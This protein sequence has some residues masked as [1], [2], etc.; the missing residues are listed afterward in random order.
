[1]IKR[2]DVKRVI[3][4]ATIRFE[5][6]WECLASLKNGSLLEHTDLSILQFQPTLAAA[7]SDLSSIYR[8]LSEEKERTIKKKS[9]L[10]YIWFA[11]RMR[12]LSSQQDVVRRVLAVGKSI[13]DGFAWFFYQN[14]T[15][16]LNEHLKE[17]PQL[18][19][20]SGVGGY[21]ELEVVKQIPVASGHFL[22]YHG[23]T[24][25]LRLGDF[26]L[27]N[28]KEF[29]VVTVGEIKAGKPV[30]GKLRVQMIF[31]CNPVTGEVLDVSMEE[32]QGNKLKDSDDVLSASAQDR[33]ARQMHRMA[34]A[35]SKLTS[36]PDRK[37]SHEMEDRLKEFD[38]FLGGLRHGRCRFMRMGDSILLIGLSMRQ[39]AMYTRMAKGSKTNWAAK[40]EGLEREALAILIPDRQDN[41]IYIGSWFYDEQGVA[42]HRPGMT[43]QVWWPISS[44][45][46]RKIIFH[47]VMLFTVYNPAHLIRGLERSGFSV[48]ESS[49][50]KFSAKKMVGDK[51]IELGGISH[52]LELIQRY[53]FSES[54]VVEVLGQV[55]NQIA[56][57]VG[58]GLGRID[59]QFVQRFGRPPEVESDDV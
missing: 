5:K 41:A 56:S 15:D 48:A 35:H 28:M 55:E 49:G 50:G 13:G 27:V 8:K 36:R 19:M 4:A 10:S 12:F 24:S 38:R 17:S 29:R 31:P 46:I 3:D 37:L 39:G 14:N 33:L 20:P 11:R 51:I 7:L 26:S 43:H 32:K 18:L 25:I 6:C 30:D 47:E 1:M 16:Y 21:A 54:D 53:F 42:P 52:Y 34:S 40:I 9:N 57:V 22:L 23:I 58:E 2:A 59:L 44:E 45:N